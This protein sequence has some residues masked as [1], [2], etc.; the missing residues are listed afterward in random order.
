MRSPPPSPSLAIRRPRA[1]SPTARNS[2][3]TSTRTPPASCEVCLGYRIVRYLKIVISD[4]E[5][6]RGF[7]GTKRQRCMVFAVLCRVSRREIRSDW[8]SSW[9]GIEAGLS[10]MAMRFDDR[11]GQSGRYCEFSFTPTEGSLRARGAVR[12]ANGMQRKKRAGLR[13]RCVYNSR[14]MA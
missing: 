14:E 7:R 2:S 6:I 8:C 4:N 10:I 11:T 1:P 12:H 9:H 13:R 3:G 5:T